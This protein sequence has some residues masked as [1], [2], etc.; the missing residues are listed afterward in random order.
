MAP[1]APAHSPPQKPRNVRAKEACYI[2]D[3]YREK[4]ATFVHDGELGNCLVEVSGEVTDP[5][6]MMNSLVK[7]I[8][9]RQTQTTG[10]HDPHA[11]EVDDGDDEDEEGDGEENSTD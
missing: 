1:K 11:G 7:G 4:G 10:T 8:P 2:G 9:L 6:A 3:V 5:E